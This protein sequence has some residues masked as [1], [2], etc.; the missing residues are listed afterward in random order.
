MKKRT[1]YSGNF[2]ELF[3]VANT[4]HLIIESFSK[5]P[6]V[7]NNKTKQVLIV[8]TDF[9]KGE[10]FYQQL[11]KGFWMFLSDIYFYKNVQ[12]T[13][14]FV[15]NAPVDYHFINLLSCSN[16]IAKNNT[17]LINGV[18]TKNNCWTI[19]KSGNV[20]T[21][22]HF[23]NTN[24]KNITFYFNDEWLTKKKKSKFN[25]SMLLDFF[26]STKKD[27]IFKENSLDAEV[28]FFDLRTLH[29]NK[30]INK[31]KY[32]TDSL[33][34]QFLSHLE[35]EVDIKQRFVVSEKSY[36]VIQKIENFLQK[37]FFDEFP[38]I[39][40]ISKE[41]NISTTKLKS[42][43]KR[44]H[45]KTIYEYF[46]FHQMQLAHE[47]LLKEKINISELAKL[48]GYKSV[49]KFSARYKKIHGI[50]PSLVEPDK[51]KKTLKG[52]MNNRGHS[53]PILNF[54]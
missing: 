34:Y 25:Q 40:G 11:E 4:P 13:N 24:D 54:H 47:I 48:L 35:D 41:L 42:D 45:Q 33:I 15:D 50:L 9:L 17:T 21:L 29:Q 8:E 44:F 31:I 52:I 7:K 26:K 22:F 1:K 5:L 6:F 16:N 46:S 23:K 43:F 51:I 3:N 28:F 30:Q 36:F 20:K 32:R 49:G 27:L 53:E 19:H 2:I 12:T 14:V 39:E 38:G 18:S 10:V 37:H